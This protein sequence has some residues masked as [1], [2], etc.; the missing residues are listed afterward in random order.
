MAWMIIA[1][2]R[3]YLITGNEAWLKIV[4]D[5]WNATYDRGWDI[6]YAAG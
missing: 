5:C 1:G 4:T 6:K 2:L 3:A